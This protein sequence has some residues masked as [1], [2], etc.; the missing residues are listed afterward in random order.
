MKFICDVHISYK[1]VK[2]LNSLGYETIHVNDIFDK[3][4]TS[5]KQISEYADQKDFIVISKDSD[6]RNSFYVERTPSKLIKISL[7]NIPNSKLIQIITDNLPQI[8]KLNKN[9]SFIVEINMN[10]VLFN[11]QKD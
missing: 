6:F 10:S 9:S 1:L 5:D 4:L 3:W 7:G 8:Q 2:Y 11:I